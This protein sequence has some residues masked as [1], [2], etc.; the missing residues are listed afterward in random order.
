[1]K[2]KNI[3]ITK[4]INEIGVSAERLRYWELKGIIA[5]K[6]IGQGSKRLRRYSYEDI[7]IARE[8]KRMIEIEGYS[9]KG[10]AERM[11]RPYKGE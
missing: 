1:M 10:A 11:N 2:E 3:G 5:P 6:Y 7:Q 4:A 9:L 8:I